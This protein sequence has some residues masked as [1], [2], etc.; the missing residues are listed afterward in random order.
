MNDDTSNQSSTH[1]EPQPRRRGLAFLAIGVVFIGLGVA[2]AFVEGMFVVA[3]TLIP[4]GVVWLILGL[5]NASSGP[6]RAA[7]PRGK[8]GDGSGA[9][10]ASDT[11]GGPR[12]G[13]RQEQSDAAD[14]SGASGAD[15]GGD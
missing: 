4:G 14:G 12:S 11:A 10:L 3:W 5:T 8:R 15:G 6:G 7:R 1:G 13:N 9:V 2:L